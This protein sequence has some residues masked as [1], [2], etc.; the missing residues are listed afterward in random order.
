MTDTKLIL[1]T[2]FLG[3]GKTSLLLKCAK[4]LAW[5][6]KKCAIIINEIG[7][8]GI[9]NLQMKKL[10]YDVWELFGGCIC[11]TM[12]I[13]LEETIQQ[14]MANY[15]IEYILMEPSGAA[16][17]TNLYQPLLHSGFTAAQI[18]NIFIMDPTRVEMFEAVLEPYLQSA[19]PLANRAVI[20]KIDLASA[21]EM[22]KSNQ[23]IKKYNEKVPIF[24]I[25]LNELTE[26][27]IEQLLN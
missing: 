15:E 22:K 10:G 18:N 24:E 14:L 26:N 23:I 4:Y 5:N 13:S 6:K 17:P 19:I 16:D 8:I 27:Q 9:D 20:N 11:C 7:E 25:N 3:S 21:E 12:A 2:G 1:F